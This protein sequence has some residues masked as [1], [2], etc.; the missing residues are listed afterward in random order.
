MWPW[1]Q[2]PQVTI[3]DVS[4][5]SHPNFLKESSFTYLPWTYPQP[6][7]IFCTTAAP[8]LLLPRSKAH[9][10][11]NMSTTSWYLP[12]LILGC[13]KCHWLL[14]MMPHFGV[15]E[16]AA[17]PPSLHQ[18]HGSSS[19]PIFS[20]LL[21]CS[22]LGDGSP[23]GLSSLALS[24]HTPERLHQRLGF[25]YYHL[26]S[27]TVGEDLR[28]FCLLLFQILSIQPQ[29]IFRWQHLLFVWGPSLVLT[30]SMGG[31]MGLHGWSCDMGLPPASSL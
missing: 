24:P 8:K 21:L 4:S 1:A 6:T 7:A 14:R 28:C 29:P 17:S 13:L 2:R 12:C 5:C 30:L 23:S 26:H 10:S 19:P 20:L 15:C 27:A 31:L 18:F 3:L 9:V 22:S 11:L 16:S 25:S